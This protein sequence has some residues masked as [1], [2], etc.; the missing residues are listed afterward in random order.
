MV[1]MKLTEDERALLAKRA[2]KEGLTE[3]DYLRMCMVLESIM[4]GDLAAVKIAGANLRKKLAEKAGMLLPEYSVA[5][6]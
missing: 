1:N 3:A 6:A 2:K 5:E 4:A